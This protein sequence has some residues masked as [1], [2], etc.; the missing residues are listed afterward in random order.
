VKAASVYA[1]R[2]KWAIVPLHDVTSGACSCGDAECRSQGKHP[3]RPAWQREATAD[4]ATVEQWIAQYPNANVGIATGAVSGFFVLDI[5]GEDGARWLEQQAALPPT[6]EALTGS[7]GRHFLFKLPGFSVRNSVRKIAKGVDIRGD[8]G[9]IVVAP[10]VSAKGAYRWVISPAQMEIAAPPDWLIDELRAGPDGRLPTAPVERGYFPPASADVLDQARFALAAHGPAVE[11]DGGDDHTFKAAALLRHDF[12]LTFEEAWPIFVEW[13]AACTPPWSESALAD[14]LRGGD[15]YGTGVYGAKRKADLLPRVRQML[16]AWRDEGANPD[17]VEALG[18]EIRQ[19]ATGV[20]PIVSE[21]IAREWVSET[22]G[23][24]RSLALPK[25]RVEGNSDIPEGAIEVTVRVDEVADQATKKIAPHVFQRFGMLCEVA[26]FKKSTLIFDLKTARIQDLMSQSASYVRR[27]KEGVTAVAPP[28]PVAQIIHERR[29]HAGIRELDAVVTSPIFLADGSVLQ[30]EG[31][32][33]A[34]RVYLK[35]NVQVSVPEAPTI[36]DAQNAVRAF[37]RMLSGFRFVEL[38][39]FCSWLAALL[40]PL[41]KASMGNAPAPMLCISAASPGAGKTL[42]ASVI[43]QII[44]GQ[45]LE[46]SSYSHEPPEL[47]KRITAIVLRGSPLGVFDDLN[48]R[49]GPDEVL[50][51]MLTSSI[52]AN[53]LLG[54]NDIPPLPNVPT[55]IATGN[56]IE[57]CGATVRR[58]MMCRVEVNE[59]NPSERGGF[60]YDLEGGFALANRGTLLSAALTILRAWHVAGRP[61]KQLAGWGSFSAW[62][63]LVRQAIVWTGLPDPYLTQR[64]AQAT[65]NDAERDAHDF[66]IGTVEA[67][68]DGSPA[69]IAVLADQRDARGILGT[70]EQFTAFTLHKWIHRFV[71]RPRGNKRIRRTFDEKRQSTSYFVERIDT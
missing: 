3:R 15:E 36:V 62:S 27:D 64:R 22:G 51:R 60:A 70:R 4:P 49:F 14:K 65:M 56:N 61:I 54:G 32:N 58:I 31:Y 17:A 47:E 42:L 1:S 45:A 38:A 34:A 8:G 55:W 28:M 18:K 2:L 48:G 69:S 52:W 29:K 7:G 53:R 19:L 12:A 66:W 63:G 9:Q 20:D 16:K 59:E 21:Q 71:D 26:P 44:N 10:S 57:P 35:P 6:V 40:T 5:D 46:T 30:D 33:D 68:V 11:G 67:A 24:V 50:D 39:D 25:A 23:N 41:V 13:N 37:Y 43:A